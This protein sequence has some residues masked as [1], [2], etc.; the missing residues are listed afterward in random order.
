MVKHYSKKEIRSY[1][2]DAFFAKS[3]KVYVKLNSFRWADL[4]I[5][6]HTMD[7]IEEEFGVKFKK[8]FLED[9]L[10]VAGTYQYPKNVSEAEAAALED[11]WDLTNRTTYF[12]GDPDKPLEQQEIILDNFDGEFIYTK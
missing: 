8:S 1:G 10:D 2:Y 5:F 4:N 11:V 6:L 7:F 9:L 3:G 12:I